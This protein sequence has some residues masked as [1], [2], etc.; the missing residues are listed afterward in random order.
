MPGENRRGRAGE[1]WLIG[2]A[3]E[4]KEKL[5]AGAVEPSVVIPVNQAFPAAQ[6]VLSDGQV[7]DIFRRAKVIART[8]CLCRTKVKGCNAPRDVCI[9]LDK[10]ARERLEKGTARRITIDDARAVLD[11]TACHGLVHLTI[12]DRGH[13]PKAICSCCSCCCHDLRAILDL[14]N[15]EMVL[16]SDFVAR[17]NEKKCQDC[18][19]CVERC[20]FGAFRQEAGKV[21]FDRKKCF[22]CGLCV[23]SCPGKALKL[24][25][26]A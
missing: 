4:R 20:R 16:E 5:K 6:K 26:R 21:S 22:G 18:G 24:T 13:V 17:R 14:G 15:P 3:R 7:L 25:R 10:A 1:K 19:K 2:Y 8:S 23:M 9:V 12:Y 11:E